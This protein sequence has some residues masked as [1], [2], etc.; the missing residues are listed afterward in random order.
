MM[1]NVRR[2]NKYRICFVFFF[3]VESY[4][5]KKVRNEIF[6]SIFGRKKNGEICFSLQNDVPMADPVKIEFE[7]PLAVDE[8]LNERQEN[9]F[10]CTVCELTFSDNEVAIQHILSHSNAQTAKFLCLKC[11]RKCSNAEEFA[12]HRQT[13]AKER[14]FRCTICK[15]QFSNAN[16]LT[17]HMLRHQSEPSIACPM[18][19]KR[20]RFRSEMEP[21]LQ[22]H[23][24]GQRTYECIY[25]KKS[26]LGLVC[27]QRHNQTHLNEKRFQCA[28][29]GKKFLR[30][31]HYKTHLR[32]HIGGKKIKCNL[33]NILVSS[34]PTLRR[35]IKNIHEPKGLKN[36]KFEPNFTCDFCP[37][38]FRL[39][40]QL[41]A[42]REKHELPCPICGKIFKG[43]ARLKRHTDDHERSVKCTICSATFSRKFGYDQHMQAMHSNDPPQ[44]CTQCGEI[45]F[46]HTVKIHM[47]KHRGA[48]L[49]RCEI[50]AKEFL[51]ASSHLRHKISHTGERKYECDV[52]G[53]RSIQQG[54]HIRHMM[55]HG[56]RKLSCPI[57]DRKFHFTQNYKRHMR[58]K[59]SSENPFL[60]EMCGEAFVTE[61]LRTIHMCAVH[62]SA[63]PPAAAAAAKV[64]EESYASVN[65]VLQVT[66]CESKPPEMQGQ[67]SE[68][69]YDGSE[70]G[71]DDNHF[72]DD[73]DSGKS[74]ER[75]LLQKRNQSM[76]GPSKYNFF[77]P[78][79]V[80]SNEGN[81]NET[82][83]HAEST[84]PLAEQYYCTFCCK[85]FDDSNEHKVHLETHSERIN[86][87]CNECNTKLSS[88]F[89]YD[90]HMNYHKTEQPW[91]CEFC[92]KLLYSDTCDRHMITH[93]GKN[94]FHCKV[95]GHKCLNAIM[96]ERHMTKK[97]GENRKLQ[98]SLCPQSFAKKTHYTRHI[99]VHS[100]ERMFVCK[101]CK[102]S[103]YALVAFKRHMLKIH[104]LDQPF[105]CDKCEQR[106]DYESDLDV[107]AQEC[108]GPVRARIKSEENNAQRFGCAHCD[109]H[110]DERNEIVKHMETHTAN[111]DKANEKETILYCETCGKKFTKATQYER[112]ILIHSKNKPFECEVCHN[113]FLDKKTY[114]K[115]LARHDKSRLFPCTKCDRKFVHRCDLRIH[116]LIHDGQTPF[117]CGTCEKTFRNANSLKRHMISH[118]GIRNYKCK[119]C[120]KDFLQSGHLAEH[121]RTHSDGPHHMCTICD[122]SFKLLLS[123]KRHMRSVHSSVKPFL[124]EKCGD[125]FA[126]EK[127]R[128]EHANI[129]ATEDAE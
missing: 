71:A 10:R 1:L 83:V 124:C 104:A 29:C 93:S 15:K 70:G 13:H 20:F 31:S 105:D 107:H 54:H 125:G 65:E 121:M 78:A 4:R 59:H 110:F 2:Q 56:E 9:N 95:C 25:C 97:H 30:S 75:I 37:Q 100:A 81:V 8:P 96:Y 115:H 24:D 7:D 50:C 26:F 40:K 57:C 62:N 63:P 14:P 111:A 53:K 99:K 116:L 123:F 85:K 61:Q 76:F 128:D 35:H 126:D 119:I 39:R 112:H 106:F 98:C 6:P 77:M 47:A 5:R 34:I 3:R 120:Q 16:T 86:L 43:P 88:K 49:Y 32:V 22:T 79:C 103:F 87:Q 68:E 72:D 89:A 46:K 129:H 82:K 122:R 28:I 36:E 33:C 17:T 55:L 108:V 45:L 117:K 67:S 12:L 113:R 91:P 101:I 52:C 44:P 84:K 42:H 27:L 64:T 92:S 109:A 51:H 73:D 114:R 80:N 48:K 41:N 118:A 69:A 90:V 21:H 18:C 38:Q 11:G 66:I 127:K 102:R 74:E 94:P 19:S 23:G 60:C 58:R